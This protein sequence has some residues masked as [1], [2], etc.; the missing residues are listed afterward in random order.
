MPS[1]PIAVVHQVR[2]LC[3]CVAIQPLAIW[4]AV[5]CL[6]LPEPA[7]LTSLLPQSSWPNSLPPQPIHAA[8][9]VAP[10][11]TVLHQPASFIIFVP[12]FPRPVSLPSWSHLSSVMPIPSA[13]HRVPSVFDFCQSEPTVSSWPWP[14][15]TTITC[16]AASAPPRKA[17]SAPETSSCSLH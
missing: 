1:S 14:R 7:A 8:R 2:S 5:V 10:T 4:W 15:R 11:S 3:R 6:P 17:T 16:L 13:L 12:S 9:P